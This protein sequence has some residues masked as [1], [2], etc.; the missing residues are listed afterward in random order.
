MSPISL[1]S[2]QVQSVPHENQHV[3]HYRLAGKLEG[4][5]SEYEF[6][7]RFRAGLTDPVT[8]IAFDFGDVGY[9]N[10]TGIGVIVSCV[11]S[12]HQQNKKVCFTNMPVKINDLFQVVGL[13]KLVQCHDDVDAAIMAQTD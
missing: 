5:A 7:E 11:T 12:A 6:L 4:A 10:S 13:F 9:L 2:F 8:L 3:Q 1:G